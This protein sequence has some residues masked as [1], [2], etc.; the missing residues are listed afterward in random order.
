MADM[1]LKPNILNTDQNLDL[2][3]ILDTEE[4]QIIQYFVKP[5]YN[6]LDNHEVRDTPYNPYE[7]IITGNGPYSLPAVTAG[8]L[9]SNQTV[10]ATH[11]Q[12]A[13]A[14]GREDMP[15][16]D[17]QD[18][19]N[20]NNGALDVLRNG[21]VVANVQTVPTDPSAK[22]SLIT[23][24]IWDDATPPEE[25]NYGCALAFTRV[26]E[27]QKIIYYLDRNN[28][29]RAMDL[30]DPYNTD[31]PVKIR[32]DA[33]LHLFYYSTIRVLG[34]TGNVAYAPL[35]VP[36][37]GAPGNSVV[38][39]FS[40]KLEVPPVTPSTVW[41]LDDD[42]Q[43]TVPLDLTG[44]RIVFHCVPFVIN[45]KPNDVP[46][47]LTG[48]N[49]NNPINIDYEGN[50]TALIFSDPAFNVGLLAQPKL[51][52]LFMFQRLKVALSSP[53]EHFLYGEVV[54]F[55]L[56]NSHVGLFGMGFIE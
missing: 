15:D 48:E 49:V 2:N 7:Y 25:R 36:T 8:G 55:Q 44:E 54:L 33:K 34:K 1:L 45:P 4:V 23:E 9:N 22:I 53:N 6:S 31:N 13:S 11:S 46:P 14:I 17:Q 5:G 39:V 32:Q 51:S 21:F 50:K 10:V 30:G 43:S 40:S 47:S 27:D 26:D 52:H 35:S 56:G 20:N 16:I 41:G 29:Y 3:R 12:M 24:V 18:Q 38:T 42:G 19:V 37:E 28:T